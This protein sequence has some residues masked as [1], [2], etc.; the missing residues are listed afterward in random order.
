MAGKISLRGVHFAYPTKPDIPVLK[1]LSLDISTG[2]TVALVGS[3]GCGKSTVTNL[4]LRFYDPAEG[5]VLVDGTDARE[6]DPR[7]LREH[8]G[9]VSQEPRLFACSIRE[10]IAYGKKNATMEEIEASAKAANAHRFI[11][12]LPEGYNTWVGEA[13]VQLSGGQKQRVAI[14]RAILRNPPILILDEA[15]SALDTQSEKLVQAAIDSMIAGGKRT[16]IIIAHRLSTIRNADMIA[17]LREG[18]VVETGTHTELLE[19][20][21]E[22]ATLVKLQ[23]AAAEIEK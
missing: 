20:N 23:I 4:L 16:T 15:T 19:K 22:Y 6:Y 21:G 7:S 17:V 8:M 10:N 2:Q 9:L 11:E 3:S 18:V 12:Q 14:A 13:G 5:A 1:G